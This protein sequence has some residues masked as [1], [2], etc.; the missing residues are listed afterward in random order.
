MK[1]SLMEGR[2]ITAYLTLQIKRA[3]GE[4][5]EWVKDLHN[6]R[7]D[8]GAD[9]MYKVLTGQLSTAGK[10]IAVSPTSQS[11]TKGMTTLPD[12]LTADG[13][14]REAGTVS[15]YTAPSTLDGAAS[16][17]ISL[18]KIYTG[19]TTQPV[20]SVGVF[21]AVTAGILVWIWNTDTTKNLSTSDQLVIT[22][23][24]NL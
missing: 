18:T 20:N 21:D 17:Q 8:A 23:T 19:E 24:V 1:L 13:L 14:A 2:K 6:D 4:I 3:N 5:E 9:W 15:G 22:L 10:F 16:Y 7:V 12:E 11:I